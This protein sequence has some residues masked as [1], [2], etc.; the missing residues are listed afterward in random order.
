MSAT[1]V[2]RVVCAAAFVAVSAT[3]AAGADPTTLVDPGRL[4]QT[5]AEPATGAALNHQMA[6]LWQAIVRD[7]VPLGWK[8]FFPE[9]AYIRMK[10]GLIPDPPGDFTG[11]LLGFY[12]LDLG[13]YHLLVAR[14]GAPT[15]VG[16]EAVH[17]DAAWIR[18]GY[19]ENLI[20][21]WHLPGV[22]LVYRHG[23]RVFSVAVFS[24]ISWRGVW[25]VVHLGPNPRPRNVGTVAG[26]ET[27]RG[28]PGPPGG[29]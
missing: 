25:Y 4:P 12:D 23:D 26:Y 21:Y 14:G 24:L 15:F 5:T 9:S 18:P 29:C 22:R 10:T 1:C 16:V 8:V 27:G 6:V 17:A 13:A 20:G 11:R 28:V 2:R 19:C 7:D 3:V